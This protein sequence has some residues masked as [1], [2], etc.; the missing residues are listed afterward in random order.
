M[1]HVR[2][3]EKIVVLKI[4]VWCCFLE[5]KLYCRIFYFSLRMVNPCNFVD[6]GKLS[7]HLNIVLCDCFLWYIFFLSIF[8][9]HRFRN[10]VYIYFNWYQSLGL[11]LSGSNDRRNRKGVW[12]RK[13]WW[14]RLWILEDADRGLPLWEEVASAALGGETYNDEKWWMN[15]SWQIGTGSYQ[16]NFV[17]VCYAQCCEREDHIRSNEGF[18]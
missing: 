17:K 9:S 18:V 8:A 5:K 14:H 7:N 10:F 12:N 4:R 3:I 16:I 13:I 2:K 6:V 15:S 11:G 1:N